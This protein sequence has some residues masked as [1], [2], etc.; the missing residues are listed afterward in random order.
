[1]QGHMHYKRRLLMAFV[2]SGG[3]AVGFGTVALPANATVRT[4]DVTLLG[5]GKIKI[6]KTVT[7]DVGLDTP[8][9]KITLPNLG[10]LPILSIRETT[11][12]NATPSSGLSL[13][14]TP[15]PMER[16]IIIVSE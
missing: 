11:P 8:L 10:S 4:F 2:V 6:K 3:M 12:A 15:T 14:L 13:T 16:V 9:D 5:I 1:M 7:V